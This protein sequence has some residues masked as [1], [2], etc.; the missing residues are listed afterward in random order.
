MDRRSDD[1]RLG[2]NRIG[3]IIGNFCLRYKPKNKKKQM[4]TFDTTI[5]HITTK[6]KAVALANEW[7]NPSIGYHTQVIRKGSG[8]ICRLVV[9]S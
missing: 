5:G 4:R 2:E 1:Q 6:E 7:R 3:E 8:Y 9:N